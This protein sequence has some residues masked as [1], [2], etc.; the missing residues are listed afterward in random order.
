M[1]VKEI[2]AIAEKMGITNSKMKKM[3]L[4]R[5]IQVQEGNS[6]CFKTEAESCDQT[7]CCW[8]NDCLA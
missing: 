1:T 4:I 5:A 8:H 7:D 6:P 2:K 3:D